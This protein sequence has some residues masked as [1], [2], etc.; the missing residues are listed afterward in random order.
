MVF[1]G[2]TRPSRRRVRHYRH[3]SGLTLNVGA[4]LIKCRQN[5]SEHSTPDASYEPPL[6]ASIA[7]CHFL[8][9]TRTTAFYSITTA[10]S[11]CPLP[12]PKLSSRSETQEKSVS[13]VCWTRRTGDTDCSANAGR[14]SRAGSVEDGRRHGVIDVE[15]R[16]SYQYNIETVLSTMQQLASQMRYLHL[17]IHLS[18]LTLRFQQQQHIEFLLYKR[19]NLTYRTQGERDCISGYQNGIILSTISLIRD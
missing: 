17:F 9:R 4:L 16:R 6:P 15:V 5:S 13:S 14:I 1:S 8:D 19:P 18:T 11:T 10:S 3:S 12:E 2:L 7:F